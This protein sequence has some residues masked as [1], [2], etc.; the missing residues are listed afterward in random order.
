M[1]AYLTMNYD[2]LNGE[3]I[4]DILGFF[5]D[6]ETDGGSPLVDTELVLYTGKDDKLREELISKCGRVYAFITS[7]YFLKEVMFALENNREIFMYREPRVMLKDMNKFSAYYAFMPRVDL[8][9]HLLNFSSLG[10]L[11]YY[12]SAEL[13]KKHGKVGPYIMVQVMISNALLDKVGKPELVSDIPLYSDDIQR[14]L[15]SRQHQV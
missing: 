5:T 7:G 10:S 6:I 9:S 3:R 11:Q 14:I 2:R 12:R 13:A 15:I 4:G 1:S 8:Y